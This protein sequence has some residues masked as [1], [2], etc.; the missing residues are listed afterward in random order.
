VV[1]EG[2]GSGDLL[3]TATNAIHHA[4]FTFTLESSA[5]VSEDTWFWHGP[6]FSFN[7]TFSRPHDWHEAFVAEFHIINIDWLIFGI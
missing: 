7:I 2:R 3:S 4:T 5:V 1:S 6:I